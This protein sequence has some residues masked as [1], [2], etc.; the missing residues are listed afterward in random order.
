MPEDDTR[1]RRSLHLDHSP[2]RY[3]STFHARSHGLTRLPPVAHVYRLLRLST[4]S[5]K[6]SAGDVCVPDT[7]QGDLSWILETTRMDRLLVRRC[8]VS[9]HEDL[10]IAMY[11][12]RTASMELEGQSLPTQRSNVQPTSSSNGTLDHLQIRCLAVGQ[13]S[14]FGARAGCCG[15]FVSHQIRSQLLKWA[16]DSSYIA[17]WIK[18]PRA[19]L[20]HRVRR[21]VTSCC[22]E[23][24]WRILYTTSQPCATCLQY[25]NVSYRQ[26]RVLREL[27]KL[28][29]VLFSLRD[30]SK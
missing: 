8:F 24:K 17:C 30:L 6:P 5:S 15:G 20:M 21:H 7:G 12:I 28:F 25:E 4:G 18:I 14:G 26:V 10:V 3:H 27:S 19:R 9:V 23:I 1:H 16:S 22:D 11:S 2:A 29:L 13:L